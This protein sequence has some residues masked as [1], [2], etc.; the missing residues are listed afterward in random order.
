MGETHMRWAA[1]PFFDTIR[2]TGRTG[3]EITLP[4]RNLISTTGV[5]I[6]G[7]VERRVLTLSGRVWV[8]TSDQIGTAI[9]RLCA[10]TQWQLSAPISFSVFFSFSLSPLTYRFLL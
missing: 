8:A 9:R 5:P 10:G 1:P 4:S 6:G 2:A 3:D 7:A